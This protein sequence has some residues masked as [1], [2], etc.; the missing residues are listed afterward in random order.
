MTGQKEMFYINDDNAVL[1]ECYLQENYKEVIVNE[2]ENLCYIFFS[3]NGLY[4]P[5]TEEE[6]KRV[7]IEKDR[8]EWENI[9]KSSFL[10][11]KAGKYIFLRDL[12]KSWYV[13][14]INSSINSIDKLYEWLKE[15][16]NGY[17]VITVGN[18]AGGYM[19]ALLG[20]M[21]QAEMIFDFSGQFSLYESGDVIQK[22]DMLKQCVGDRE[23]EKYWDIRQYIK[24]NSNI[25]YFWPGQCE[26]DI[27]QYDLVKDM[28]ICSF[29]FKAHIHGESMYG[30]NIP[31]LLVQDKQYMLDLNKHYEE[32]AINKEKFFFRTAG[33]IPFVKM[34]IAFQKEKMRK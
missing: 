31:Y 15:K 24:G 13:K 25:M 9:A 29:K 12:Y 4:F 3:G 8:Y 28:G 17:R 22:Y 34:C 1:R 18:S 26:A 5:N 33:V 32:K 11:E 27:K 16:T 10:Q 7:I 30:A 21:L 6:F 20:S 2:E 19:A 23:R 14:G